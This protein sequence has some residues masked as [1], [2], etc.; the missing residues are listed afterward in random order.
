M[1]VY[2][3]TKSLSVRAEVHNYTRKVLA[4]PCYLTGPC[5]HP[6]PNPWKPLKMA[7]SVRMN[8]SVR[9]AWAM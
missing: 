4:Q 3:V 2:K 1:Q 6:Y 7:H 5:M 8:Y 9:I